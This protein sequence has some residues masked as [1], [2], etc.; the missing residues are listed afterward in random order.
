[1]SKQRL[2]NI[3]LALSAGVLFCLLL[4]RSQQIDANQHSRYRSDLRQLEGLHAT[5]NESVLQA[6]LG[7]LSYYDPL[8][9]AV[10]ELGAVRNR[11]DQAPGFVD[12]QG[13]ATIQASLAVYDDF[14]RQKQDLVERF[15]L[16]DAVLSNSLSYFTIVVSELAADTRQGL[17]VPT[18][19]RTLNG[20]LQDILLY[21]FTANP[22]LVPA[23]QAY[24]DTLLNHALEADETALRDNLEINTVINHTN[25]ILERKPILDNLVTDLLAVP[26]SGQIASLIT[27][28]D[29]QYETALGVAQFY[30]L[31]L[32][33][34]TVAALGYIALNIILRLQF[35]ADTLRHARDELQITYNDLEVQTDQLETANAER[36]R[37][38]ADLQQAIHVKDSFLATMSHEL[39]TPL[40]A[41][42]GYSGILTM[43]ISGAIDEEAGELI[44]SIA[45]S[46]EH[47]LGLIN[48]VLDIAKIESGRL[49]IITAPLNIRTLVQTWH[50]RIGVLARPKG[51]ALDVI[52]DP[53]LPE[54]LL[55]DEERLTQIATNLLSNAVKFTDNGRVSLELHAQRGHWVMEVTD[56]GIGIPPH[57]LD[58]IF[59][60][61]R[62]VDGTY[63]RSYGGTGLGLAIV[64]KLCESMDGHVQVQS[65][66]G[67]GSTFTVTLPLCTI[68]SK[69]V[70]GV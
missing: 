30:Q 38:I 21:N 42:I 17:F 22:E 40:N 61:F 68:E 16:Q 51:L 58:Y 18:D 39:R 8:N 70:P 65:Q 10:A 19:Q 15:K 69:P 60:E 12:P 64:N 53:D 32:V 3:V 28:Y 54:L 48:E 9:L 5:L 46:S 33:L 13:V 23:I 11:L 35:S 55:G 67:I 37:L 36:N 2:L 43:G 56:T 50:N 6:R 24:R 14:M 31:M 25:I 62:Q 49:E 20:L 26:V 47:L 45:E 27:F 44:S 1:M 52:V 7:L 29:Q 41:I 63:R 4:I 57:A 34:F 59:D 66:L